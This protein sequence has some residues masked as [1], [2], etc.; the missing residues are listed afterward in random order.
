MNETDKTYL[1]T[2]T[3]LQVKITERMSRSISNERDFMFAVMT[4]RANNPG[5]RFYRKAFRD[6]FMAGKASTQ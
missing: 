2:P 4:W 5:K 1:P 6:G 3:S